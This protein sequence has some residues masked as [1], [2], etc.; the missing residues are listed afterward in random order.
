MPSPLGP[1][2]LAPSKPGLRMSMLNP[3]GPTAEKVISVG[4]GVGDVCEADRTKGLDVAHKAVTAGQ[5]SLI[6]D[7]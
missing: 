1:P 5:A 3:Q 6:A 7:G 2:T 4:V